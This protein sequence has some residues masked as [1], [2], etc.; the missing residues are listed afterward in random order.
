ML[1]ALASHGVTATQKVRV[2]DRNIRP[3]VSS[4]E[5]DQANR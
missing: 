1:A 5:G 2:S 3:G 4:H